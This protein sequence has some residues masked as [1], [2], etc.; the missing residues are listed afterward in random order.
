[1]SLKDD[2]ASDGGF[3]QNVKFGKTPEV[4]LAFEQQMTDIV[5]FCT[6]PVSFSVLGID[7]TFN[8]G[9]F[10]VTITTYKHPM[11]VLKESKQHPVF[12]GPSFIHM[13]QSTQSYYSFLFH[14]V[15]QKPSLTDLQAYG[16]DGEVALLNA[17]LAVFGQNTIGLRCFIHMKNNLEDKLLKK[18]MVKPEVKSTI[19][20]D[21][22]GYKLGDT[23]VTLCY[24]IPNKYLLLHLLAIKIKKAFITEIIVK[25]IY[26]S[27]FR[28]S[29]NS[30]SQHVIH[31]TKK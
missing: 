23:K 29:P 22:F 27:F 31:I 26:I 4:I 7:P 3:I 13:E 20:H 8:L 15:G 21:I 10:F 12:V 11:L 16:S 9:K 17:L 18:F 30:N 1:M 24:K 6:N 28:G 25:K 14:L 2:N 5:R 19:I